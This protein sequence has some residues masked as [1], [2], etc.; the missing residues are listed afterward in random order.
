MGRKC[1]IC[2]SKK[3]PEI[4]DMILEGCLL[5]EVAE[6]F[7]ISVG[8]VF[9]HKMHMMKGANRLE[10]LKRAYLN[11]KDQLTP[12]KQEYYENLIRKYEE[13]LKNEST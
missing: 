6:E 2:M 4:E 9:R 12:K 1:V 5:R 11:V 13:N 10:R 3:R 8:C 7:N